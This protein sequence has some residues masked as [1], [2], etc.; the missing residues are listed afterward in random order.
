MAVVPIVFP[1]SAP[2][3]Y[4]DDRKYTIAAIIDRRWITMA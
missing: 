2:V 3:V 4:G 1:M